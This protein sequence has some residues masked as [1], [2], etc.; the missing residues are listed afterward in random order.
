MRIVFEQVAVVYE[1]ELLWSLSPHTG[2][3]ACVNV[4]VCV[5]VPVLSACVEVVL[6][7]WRVRCSVQAAVGQELW[8]EE[9]G[10][11]GEQ[12]GR[13]SR[14]QRVCTHCRDNQILSSNSQNPPSDT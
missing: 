2:R 5:H 10:A 9:D 7:A 1:H 12:P 13:L 11:G 14:Q 8:I 6:G 3:A 4:C